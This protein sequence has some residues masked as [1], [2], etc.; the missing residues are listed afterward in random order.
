MVP[1]TEA[2]PLS[3]FLSNIGRLASLEE[4]EM[5]YPFCIMTNP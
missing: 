3:D 1:L 4:K 5:N 2:K